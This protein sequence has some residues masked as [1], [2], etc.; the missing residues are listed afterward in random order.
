MK[1]RIVLIATA[2]AA[3]GLSNAYA[4]EEAASALDGDIAKVGQEGVDAGD[5]GAERPV[6]VSLGLGIEYDSNVAVLELDTTSNAGDAAVLYEFGVNYDKPDE[7]RFDF[8]AGYNFSQTRHQ[9]FDAFDVG[10]H[11]GSATLAWKLEGVS[12]GA[13]LQYA[14]ASLDGD[15]F[16]VLEQF[17]P[18]MQKL[19]NKRLFL[20]F[21]PAYTEKSF[22]GKEDRDAESISLSSDAYVFLNGLTTYLVLGHRYHDESARDPQFDYAG[23]RLKLQLNRRFEVGSR[24]LTLKTYLRY[25]TRDYSHPTPS[26]EAER[27]D[28]RYQFEALAALPLTEHVH[29]TFGYKHADNQSNLSNVDFSENVYSM[30]LGAEF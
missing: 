12:T 19:V 14:H 27:R 1:Q 24:T 28:D 11:R 29:A 16:L 4:D 21:A 23:H 30:K 5:E 26:I 6:T 17:S 3:A 13:N 10:I 22:A 8:R 15:E 18:Y 7:G 25:E 9:D 2:V 20:R